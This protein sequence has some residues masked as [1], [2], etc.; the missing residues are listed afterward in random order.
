MIAGIEDDVFDRLARL[1]DRND[2]HFNSPPAV[3]HPTTGR[4]H[5]SGT[6]ARID[7]SSSCRRTPAAQSAP[8]HRTIP[9][10]TLLPI[11]LI[12]SWRQSGSRCATAKGPC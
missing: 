7:H 3:P 5:G 9:S 2:N 4:S 1:K 11:P 6:A 12:V 10:M 8:A